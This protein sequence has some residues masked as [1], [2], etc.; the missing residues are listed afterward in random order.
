[1]KRPT[2]L[3]DEYRLRVVWNWHSVW[4]IGF[5]HTDKRWELVLGPLAIEWAPRY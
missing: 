3:A 4:E 2:G 1:M 5:W